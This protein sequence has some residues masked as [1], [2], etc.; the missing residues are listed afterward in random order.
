MESF[1][2]IPLMEKIFVFIT[3]WKVECLL[4]IADTYFQEESCRYL[5]KYNFSCP[6]NLI[7]SIYNLRKKG[8]VSNE[9]R[10]L[11]EQWRLQYNTF[12]L[13]STLN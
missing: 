3:Y 13:Y 10:K 2:L 12:R 6:Q 5:L 8:R 11:T 7:M 1:T 4:K 9:A